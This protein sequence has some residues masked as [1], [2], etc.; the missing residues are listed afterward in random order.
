MPGFFVESSGNWTKVRDD[1]QTKYSGQRRNPVLG[2]GGNLHDPSGKFP[3]KP[4]LNYR[5]R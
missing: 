3:K 4:Y 2:V 1:T 5:V